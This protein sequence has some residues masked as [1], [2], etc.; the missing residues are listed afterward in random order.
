MKCF[1]CPAHEAQPA[2]PDRM[3]ELVEPM[4]KLHV[5]AHGLRLTAYGM[6]KSRETSESARGFA[7][8]TESR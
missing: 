2:M 4:L 8:W 5:R 1:G 3:V 7:P 6:R